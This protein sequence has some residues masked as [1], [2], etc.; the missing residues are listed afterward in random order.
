MGDEERGDGQRKGQDKDTWDKERGGD[1]GDKRGDDTDGND[2][3]TDEQ[4]SEEGRDE[5]EGESTKGGG[6]KEQR[7]NLW[8][9]ILINPEQMPNNSNSKK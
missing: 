5:F 9:V 3:R 8:S 6:G 7:Q 2:E 4:V 1:E